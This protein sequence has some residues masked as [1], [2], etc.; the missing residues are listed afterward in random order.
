MISTKTDKNNHGIGISNIK[1]VAK[2]Y[3]G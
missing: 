1:T 3:N 2:K